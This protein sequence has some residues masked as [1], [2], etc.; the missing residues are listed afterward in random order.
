MF[1]PGKVVL[2]AMSRKSPTISK[3]WTSRTGKNTAGVQQ[4]DAPK[5]E[6]SDNGTNLF[7]FQMENKPSC[8]NMYWTYQ[9]K[10][11][12]EFQTSSVFGQVGYVRSSHVQNRTTVP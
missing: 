2:D 12:S 7:G 11:T 6:T 1:V 5:L 9:E 8:Q 3:T 10:L 4:K